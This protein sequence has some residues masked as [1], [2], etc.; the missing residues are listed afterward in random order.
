MLKKE[1]VALIVIDVQGSLAEQAQKNDNLIYNIQT[2][3]MAFQILDIPII[4]MEQ[5]PEGLGCSVA[6]IS[7]LLS[8]N[9]VI[10]KTSFSGCGSVEFMQQLK[11]INKKQ[12]LICGI[13]THV[14]VYQTVMD[15]LKKNLYVEVITDAV[16]S[17]TQE[18][19][20]LALN[21]M[22]HLGASLTSVEMCLFEMMKDSKIEKFKEISLLFKART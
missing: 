2:L 8:N 12:L 9:K 5:Y 1:D 4:Y 6:E 3:I 16:S 7:S 20:Q 10:V 18:N 15:L 22:Q 21:K 19:K 11:T 13:E 14:C 17:R